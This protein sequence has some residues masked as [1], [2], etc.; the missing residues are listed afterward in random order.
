MKVVKT[1]PVKAWRP[2]LQ[3]IDLENTIPID[4]GGRCS[5]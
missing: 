4:A 2:S 5:V 1:M 3:P